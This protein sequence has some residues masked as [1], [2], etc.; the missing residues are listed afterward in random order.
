MYIFAF[1]SYPILNTINIIFI[2]NIYLYASIHHSSLHIYSTTSCHRMLCSVSAMHFS[3]NCKYSL[4][5]C[6]YLKICVV[7]INVYLHICQLLFSTFFASNYI[8]NYV[9]N[10][11]ITKEPI[12]SFFAIRQ[13]LNPFP[14]TSY[15]VQ[16]LKALRNPSILHSIYTICQIHRGLSMGNQY[17]RLFIARLL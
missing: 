14:P 6:L 3:I 15:Y 10:N 12:D 8:L 9:F 5:Y 11:S 7:I 13:V 2:L 1:I 17:Y 4:K 16:I